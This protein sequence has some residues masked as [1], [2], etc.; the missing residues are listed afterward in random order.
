M[1]WVSTAA[2]RRKENFVDERAEGKIGGRFDVYV[3]FGSCQ[4]IEPA[5]LSNPAEE[6]FLRRFSTKALVAD[7]ILASLYLTEAA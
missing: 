2:G 7:A 3:R 6:A 4:S 1:A 5:F